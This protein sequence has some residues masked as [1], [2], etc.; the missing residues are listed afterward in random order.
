MPGTGFP[1]L[2]AA[3]AGLVAGFGPDPIAGLSAK[4]AVALLL[5]AAGAL[6]LT[7]WAVERAR[8][9]WRETAGALAMWAIFLASLT[10]VWVKRDAAL[11]GLRSV[12]E[13]A[14]L[15]PPV[16][17]V[18]SGG[19]VV[20]TRRRDGTFVLPASVNGQ[21]HTFLFDTGASS[22]VLTIETARQ[23]G[24]KVDDLQ[25]RIPVYTANGRTF[26]APTTIA[27]LAIGPITLSRVAALVA[28]PGLLHQ[29]LLGQTA[30]DRLESYEVRGNRLVLRARNG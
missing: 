11:E 20:V 17:A 13:D 28:G 10:A 22:V 9:S 16:A 2:L 8:P 18:T 6:W 30:L 21:S 1:L 14:G 4:D 29:N 15:S 25:F 26:A 5:Y 3:A 27:T 19:E 12:A 24:V 23:L 7:A